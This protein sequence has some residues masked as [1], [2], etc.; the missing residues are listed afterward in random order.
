MPDTL[1]VNNAT[2]A[3][4]CTKAE[5]L[6]IM[7]R[8]IFQTLTRTGCM[9][10]LALGLS[11]C[12]DGVKFP[13]FSGDKT[14]DTAPSSS[15]Q[16]VERDVEAPDVFDKTDRGLW[17]GRPSLGGVW[18]AHPDVKEPERVIIRNQ[19]NGAFVIGALFRKELNTPGPKFQ[20]SSD[21]ANALKMLAGAP[22]TI[23]VVALRREEAPTEATPAPTGDT[24]TDAPTGDATAPTPTV[25]ATPLTDA[26]APAAPAKTSPLS[27]PYVQIGIFSVEANAKRTADQLRAAGV[28]PTI[29]QSSS[30]GK[31]FYRVLIGPAQTKAE[32][33]AL[34]AT[35]KGQG[36][37]DAYFVSN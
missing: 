30:A 37:A 24:P 3:P 18:V 14:I 8:P 1:L 22:A 12:E 16:L 34:L 36:F 9:A 10:A 11:A 28:V 2:R 35:A 19:D 25:A 31:T 29:T 4:R 32:R 21:A 5:L 33:D 27:K 13:T 26:P 15:V 6:K 7:S 17:D 20:V 23:N